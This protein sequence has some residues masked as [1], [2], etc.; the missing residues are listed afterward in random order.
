M[1]NMEKHYDASSEDP[2]KVIELDPITTFGDGELKD[3]TF[4]HADPNDA[5]EALKVFAGHEGE[6]I[7]LTFAEEEGLLRNIDLNLM[8]VCH[9][10]IRTG[11][12]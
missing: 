9:R 8:L 5:D 6:T 3:I 11:S 12:S 1:A 2:E 7:V 10:P 4:K